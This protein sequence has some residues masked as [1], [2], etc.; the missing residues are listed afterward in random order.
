MS[1]GTFTKTGAKSTVPAKLDDSVFSVS[2]KNYELLKAAYV[3]YLANGRQNL[4]VAKTRGQVRGG[5]RKP[6]RQKGTGRARFGSSRNPIWRAGGAAFGPTG[7]ENY[8][9]N[10]P[11]AQKRQALR[12]ALSLAAKEGR[13]KVIEA[14]ECSEGKIAQTAKLLQK[15]EAK[16][17]VLLA[18]SVKDDLVVRATRNLLHV[19]AVDAKYLTVFDILNADTIVVSQKALE[20]INQWLGKNNG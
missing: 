5:G 13:I 14:F 11:T 8:V 17:S 16:G 9:H 20:A 15:I 18:V 19:K 4:A 12:Q 10:L 1:V 7:R 3:A 6:W 2:V